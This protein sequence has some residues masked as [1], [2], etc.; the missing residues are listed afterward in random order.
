MAAKMRKSSRK[1]KKPPEKEV[2]ALKAGKVKISKA[3]LTAFMKQLQ[4]QG[5]T[6]PKVRFVA[7]NAPFMRRAP[8]LPV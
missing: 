5:I 4:K 3:K 6:S 7:R 1:V 2:G 8:I